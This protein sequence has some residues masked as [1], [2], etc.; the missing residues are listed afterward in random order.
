MPKALMDKSCEPQCES[1]N[2][3]WPRYKKDA[4]GQPPDKG[5][6]NT[7]DEELGKQPK[8]LPGLE[9]EARKR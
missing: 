4:D 3:M 6:T 5:E 7:L 2:L 8:D 9:G 1:V